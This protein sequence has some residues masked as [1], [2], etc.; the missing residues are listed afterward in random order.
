MIKLKIIYIL[1][2][3]ILSTIIDK[4]TYLIYHYTMAATKKNR[5]GPRK[6]IEYN[7][8]H[9]CITPTNKLYWTKTKDKYRRISSR[10]TKRVYRTRYMTWTNRRDLFKS[11]SNFVYNCKLKKFE[12]YLKRQCIMT[13]TLCNK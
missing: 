6:M 9:Q 13:I 11:K 2:Y 12:H 4:E 1:T 5:N 7:Q 8:G 10:N 3:M